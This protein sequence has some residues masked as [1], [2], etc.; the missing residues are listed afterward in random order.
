LTQGARGFG[1]G[2]APRPPPR[3]AHLRA[4]V[5]RGVH[6]ALLEGTCVARAI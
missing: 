4:L 2:D 1:D 3:H 5:P 6:H